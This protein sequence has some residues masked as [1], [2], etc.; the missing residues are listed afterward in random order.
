MDEKIELNANEAK[1]LN[2]LLG[3]FQAEMRAARGNPRG[4]NHGDTQDAIAAATTL[5]A[6]LG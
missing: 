4:W 5:L 2:H 3:R 6:K 1:L